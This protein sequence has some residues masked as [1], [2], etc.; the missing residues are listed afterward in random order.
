MLVLSWWLAGRT[1]CIK[2]TYQLVSHF[3]TVNI[4]GCWRVLLSPRRK[5]TSTLLENC[6]SSW[7]CLYPCCCHFMF[8]STPL[9]VYSWRFLHSEFEIWLHYIPHIHHLSVCSIFFYPDTLGKCICQMR[10]NILIVFL[11]EICSHEGAEA[12]NTQEHMWHV[13]AAVIAYCF[14]SQL[15]RCITQQDLN[16]TRYLLCIHDVF[17]ANH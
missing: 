11:H 8:S 3:Y 10:T 17:F 14:F 16:Y 1:I 6:P 13:C 15:Y 7:A 12:A 2:G 5:S 9:L 4:W